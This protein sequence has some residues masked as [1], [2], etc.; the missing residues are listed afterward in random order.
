MSQ[1]TWKTKRHSE[2]DRLRHQYFSFLSRHVSHCMD[3]DF[4]PLDGIIL[5]R[6]G[7]LIILAV[8]AVLLALLSP[9][10]VLGLVC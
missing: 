9:W 10:F 3:R 1:A 4:S 7:G 6:S 8:F 5:S 2:Y